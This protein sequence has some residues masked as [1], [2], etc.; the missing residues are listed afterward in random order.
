MTYSNVKITQ[1]C[2][3]TKKTLFPNFIHTQFILIKLQN[4]GV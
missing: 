3:L 2:L 1:R 4:Q